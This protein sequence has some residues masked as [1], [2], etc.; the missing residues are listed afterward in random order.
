MYFTPIIPVN[1][2][3]LFTGFIA[4]AVLLTVFVSQYGF[5]MRPCALCLWQR[6][7]Y[8]GLLI[9]G[10]GM[11]YLACK[12]SSLVVFSVLIFVLWATGFAISLF[13]VGVEQHWWEFH[14]ACSGNVYEAGSSPDEMLAHLKA[15]PVTRCDQSADFLFGW[16]MAVWN[17]LLS[18]TMTVISL[19]MSVFIYR[20]LFTPDAPAKM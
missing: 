8:A 12:R 10:F 19:G 5:G 11:H 13:H 20:A 7:P 6:Y 9:M 1:R 17:A 3:G 14:S 15:A 16:S 18:A 4:L 2:Y